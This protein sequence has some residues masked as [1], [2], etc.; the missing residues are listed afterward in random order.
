MNLTY[1][2]L[3]SLTCGP[4]IKVFL[5]LCECL[6]SPITWLI[7]VFSSNSEEAGP[8]CVYVYTSGLMMG[9]THAAV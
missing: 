3:L 2:S 5:A 6:F 1:M 4:L 7:S 9:A 8:C